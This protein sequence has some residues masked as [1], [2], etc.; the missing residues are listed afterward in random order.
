MTQIDGQ[1]KQHTNTHF[2]TSQDIVC[3]GADATPL[4][5]FHSAEP[6]PPARLPSGQHHRIHL[7]H[8]LRALKLVEVEADQQHRLQCHKVGQLDKKT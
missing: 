3:T 4:F 2:Q 5:T 8:R 6:E 7:P 1:P